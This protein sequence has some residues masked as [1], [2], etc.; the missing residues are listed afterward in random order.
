[1]RIAVIECLFEL[2]GG[3]FEMIVRAASSDGRSFL[4]DAST[5]LAG[6]TVKNRRHERSVC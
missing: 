3:V 5:L 4:L 2:I 6:G 1:M